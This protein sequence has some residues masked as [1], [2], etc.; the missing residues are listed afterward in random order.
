MKVKILEK[1]SASA[2]ARLTSMSEVSLTEDTG[3]AEVL[4]IR[5]QTK[6]DKNFLEHAPSLKL[7]VTATSGFDHVEWRECQARGIVVTHTPEANA[8]STAELAM[9]LILA[10]ERHLISARK[11]VRENHWRDGLKR[12]RG[13]QGQTLGIIGLGRV[14]SRVCKLATGFGMKICAHDPYIDENLFSELGAERLGL[15][16]VFRSSDYVSLHV[17]LTRETKHLMNNPTLAE[18]QSDAVLINTCRGAVV[19][20]NALLTALDENVIAGAA[21]DV[22]E[23]EPPPSGHR[24]RLHPKLLLTPHIGA[25]TEHAWEQG[26][27]EAVEKILRFQ[28]G[29]PISDTLP[30]SAPWF[31]K[32]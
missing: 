5:S 4:L 13:L 10:S 7:V 2:V 19:D 28:Q 24:S 29:L 20:E 27:M 11:H 23:R 31:D 18:M 25:Y 15:I 21:M 22:I 16:E 6:V 14:G 30:L 3:A 9:L 17:P 8:S 32:T 1:H 12:S 26:S